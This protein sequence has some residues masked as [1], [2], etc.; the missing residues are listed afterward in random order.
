MQPVWR[1]I[2]VRQLAGE[3]GEGR[4]GVE[5]NH[6][7]VRAME[8]RAVVRER[9]DGL[10]VGILLC[11]VPVATPFITEVEPL[12]VRPRLRNRTEVGL[13]VRHDGTSKD[14]GEASHTEMGE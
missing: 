12:K 9:D 13:G 3:A 8:T 10:Q 6:R 11:P 14:H 1:R 4:G 5:K 2:T 7:K